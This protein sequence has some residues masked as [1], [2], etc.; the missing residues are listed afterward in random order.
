MSQYEANLT[1]NLSTVLFEKTYWTAPQYSFEVVPFYQLNAAASNSGYYTIQETPTD[2]NVDKTLVLDTNGSNVVFCDTTDVMRGMQVT[3][4]TL[5]SCSYDPIANPTP[6][7]NVCWPLFGAD[8]RVKEVDHANSRVMLT[9]T[10]TLSSGD[11]LNFSTMVAKKFTVKFLGNTDVPCSDHHVIDWAHS[12]SLTPLAQGTQPLIINTN[13]N[14]NNVD[15]AG[16]TRTVTISGTKLAAG[17]SLTVVRDDDFYHY[18]FDRNTFTSG[19]SGVTSEKIGSTGY[20]STGITFPQI[21][22]DKAYTVTITPLVTENTWDTTIASADVVLQYKLN[23]HTSKTVTF[24]TT[25]TGFVVGG[26][27]GGTVQTGI[28]GANANVPIVAKSGA[29]T[30]SDGAV[31]YLVRSLRG[32]GGSRDIDGEPRGDFKVGNNNLSK[33]YQGKLTPTLTGS[34]TA[35]LTVGYTGIINKFPTE[36]IDVSLVLDS[37][38]TVKPTVPDKDTDS[39]EGLLVSIETGFIDIDVRGFDTDG[40]AENKVLSTEKNPSLGTLTAYGASGSAWDDGRIRYSIAEGVVVEPGSTDSFVY[41]ATVGGVD[42]EEEGNGT[43]TV[44]FK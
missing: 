1:P 9:E 30:K 42:G 10:N 41:K 7:A 37:L 31:L 29:V 6:G 14:T 16:E 8:I 24:S 4:P 19:F 25:A 5:V 17:F 20:Y 35:S 39:D 33:S 22:S 27:L 11:V 15:P 12:G 23:Q 43:I 21:V 13:F 40:N 18:D 38:I 28:G 3:G 26:N 2:Y 36:N 44:K 34:G 32:T